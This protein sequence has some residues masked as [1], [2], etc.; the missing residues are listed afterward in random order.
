M[1][2]ENVAQFKCLGRI[3]GELATYYCRV[4]EICCG[5]DIE[6]PVKTEDFISL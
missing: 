2:F 5:I 3:E 1:S 6:F 4:R